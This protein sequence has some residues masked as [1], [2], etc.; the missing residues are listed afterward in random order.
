MSIELG[1]LIT[2]NLIL[3]INLAEYLESS[4][5]IYMYKKR[6]FRKLGKN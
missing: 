2:L 4:K 5:K 6:I 1:I 3:L